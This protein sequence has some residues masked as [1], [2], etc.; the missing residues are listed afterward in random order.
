MV[1]VNYHLFYLVDYRDE[2]VPQPWDLQ[3]SNGLVCPLTSGGVVITGTD[4][5]K[6]AV[7]V[8]PLDFEPELS[9]QG[10]DEG[11]DVS[12]YAPH[13]RL[14]VDAVAY[15]YPGLPRLTKHGP[16]WYRIRCLARNRLAEM[17]AIKDRAGTEAFSLACWPAPRAP[18]RIHRLEW[19]IGRAL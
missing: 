18:E 14:Y 5:G 8:S 12:V 15:D 16:G 19:S 11:A 2:T 9:L 1:T 13:G 4:M 6:V 7:H 17:N 10:W 3:G